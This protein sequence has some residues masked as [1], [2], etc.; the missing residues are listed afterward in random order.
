VQQIMPIDSFTVLLFGLFV[1]LLLAVVFGAFWL[2]N[3]S[4]LWFAWWGAAL[5]SGSV[6]SALFMLRASGE[7]FLTIGIGNAFLMGAFACVWQG[8]RTFEKR[9]PLW[10][11]ALAAPAI[12]LA[13]SLVPGFIEAVEYRIALS[14]TIV[15]VLLVLAALETWRGRAEA[16]ASRWPVILILCSLT[17]FF[18]LRIPLMGFLPFPFGALP[19]QVGW[20]GAFNLIMF[21]HTFLLVVL[22][23]AM[24]KERLE[25]DQR[26][27]AQ[28]DPLTG[29]LNRR[30]FMA[31]GER[32]VARHRHEDATLSLL[33][34]DLD[35]FKS[36]ND[37]F[38]HSGGD[39]VLTCFVGL[40]NACIRPS[41]FL[42]R[43]GGEE[44]C[45]LLPG[46]DTEQAQRVAERI[47]HQVEEASVIVAGQP[48]RATVSIG[49]AST[50]TVGHDLDALIRRAD[51]A[52]YAA[53]RSGR[54][55]VEVASVDETAV[56]AAGSGG[57]VLAAG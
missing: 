39:D 43:M 37:R 53:K 36:L 44:F 40:V 55:R 28:T 50:E 6:T 34:L 35:H 4:S 46:T 3:R 21:G 30:A 42:F 17:L 2:N 32:L 23:V 41:D 38:G 1:K 52:V 13:A 10:L 31:R 33:F 48:V 29:A 26:T 19:M 11:P 54:N 22:M 47:R 16:L 9:A 18:A 14:S 12:W 25:L 5:A 8:S 51:S 27:K 15:S 56:R 24:S 57:P 49:I 45:C 7:N 20:L